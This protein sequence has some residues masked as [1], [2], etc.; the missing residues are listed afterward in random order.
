MIKKALL[1]L[2]L[3]A[4]AIPALALPPQ[5]SC[6][7]CAGHGTSSCTIVPSNTV[8][9]CGTYYGTYCTGPDLAPQ[10]AVPSKEQFLAS[11]GSPAGN[12]CR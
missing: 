2:F 6:P 8:T 11:L 4:L 10:A 7:Y 1:A 12:S 9:S 5:C 3:L